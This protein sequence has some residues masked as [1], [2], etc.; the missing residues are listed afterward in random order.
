M[1]TDLLIIL[2]FLFFSTL[3]QKNIE[4]RKLEETNSIESE[5]YENI[6]D[7]ESTDFEPST[8]IIS[9]IPTTTT[10]YTIPEDAK[11][12][13]IGYSDYHA[14]S[15]FLYF[16]VHFKTSYGTLPEKMNFTV[17]VNYKRRLRFLEENNAECKLIVN[18]QN[19]NC[20]VQGLN[21]SKEIDNVESKNDF[22]FIQNNNQ[23][24]I[25]SLAN[26]EKDN[27]DK[28]VKINFDNVI[29][30]NNATLENEEPIQFIIK[31]ELEKDLEPEDK[32]AIFYFDNKDGNLTN[33]SCS[34]KKEEEEYSF[35][36]KPK[37]SFYNAN[38]KN[39]AGITNS[40][41]TTILVNFN[42]GTPDTFDFDVL[43]N[44]PGTKSSSKGLSGGA[45][46]GIVISCVIVLIAIA[47]V[48]FVCL[49]KP[50][51]PI[52][53]YNSSSLENQNSSIKV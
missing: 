3:E 17:N 5:P 34:I 24:I 15:S 8:S 53:G 25:T 36:C 19:Y 50:K 27:I 42:E 9:S 4:I 1:K 6:T 2:S 20:T 35:E 16:I 28:Q 51:A 52:N 46:A 7:L 41:N 29:F 49:R 23:L 38:L 33:V 10:N 40:S 43:L 31:G 48:F 37:N 30:L 45:I 47:I 44:R 21:T 22:S 32:E 14:E 26:A 39:V 11:I 13:L 12:Y 18:S